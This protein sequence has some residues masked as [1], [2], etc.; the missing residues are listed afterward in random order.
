MLLAFY[1]VDLFPKSV[2]FTYV[3][4]KN[5]RST[6]SAI[7]LHFMINFTGQ[8]FELAPLTEGLVTALYLLA[9]LYLYIRNRN[10]FK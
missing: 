6:L 1:F 10:I 7:L 5:Q 2:I 3:F 9:A 4:F 8:L